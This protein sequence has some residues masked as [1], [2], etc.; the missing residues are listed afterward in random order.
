VVC[1]TLLPFEGSFY[2]T[3]QTEELRQQANAWLRGSGECDA[4]IDFDEGMRD[5]AHPRRLRAEYDSGDQLHPND[6]GYRAMADFVDLRIF[7]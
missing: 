1:G 2:Y 3:E 6:V 4:L 7:R 5:P